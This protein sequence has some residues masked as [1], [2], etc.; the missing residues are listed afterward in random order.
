MELITTDGKPI[1]HMKDAE[2][3]E[4]FVALTE[5][6]FLHGCCDCGLF[7]Q[8]EWKLVDRPEWA[9]PN[10][11]DK[12]LAL[13]FTRDVEQT[14]HFRGQTAL[15]HANFDLQAKRIEQQGEEI[16]RLQK[17]VNRL[18]DCDTACGEIHMICGSAGIPSGYVVARVRKLVEMQ[19]INELSAYT[20]GM[21][22]A[23]EIADNTLY[24]LMRMRKLGEAS[25]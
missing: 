12:L 20:A 8:V 4:R 10:L 11:P 21:E 22:A 5:N 1:T 13:R 3:D 16:E 9:D 25:K 23:A 24:R 7:H 19:Q 15:N 14:E 17:E 2:D 6:P 18:K